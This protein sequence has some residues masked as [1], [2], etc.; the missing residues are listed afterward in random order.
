MRPTLSTA[1]RRLLI[2]AAVSLL[3]A[4]AHP[5]TMTADPAA[6]KPAAERRIPITVG[7]WITPDDRARE[8]TTPGGGGDKVR[9]F[10]YRDLESGLYQTL[11]GVFQD[12]RRLDGP[13]TAERLAA[14]GIQAVLVPRLTTQSSSDSILTWPPTAFSIELECRILDARGTDVGAAR[15]TGFGNATFSEFRSDF[16][17]AAKRAATDVLNRLADTLPTHEAFR[18]P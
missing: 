4:C 3:G 12:A 5:I 8:V 7:Y 13:P 10:P 9:Y 18:R 6:L 2:V 1:L 15:V 11:N 17:L 14:A 16:S